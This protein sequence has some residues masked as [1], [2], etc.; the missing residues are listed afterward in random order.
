MLTLDSYMEHPIPVIP[1]IV[2]SLPFVGKFIRNERIG[3]LDFILTKKAIIIH[4]RSW[5]YHE[6]RKFHWNVKKGV[7]LNKSVLMLSWWW[8]K[9]IVI[10]DAKTGEVYIGD[11]ITINQICNRWVTKTTKT[12]TPIYA[13][14]ISLLYRYKGEDLKQAWLKLKRLGRGKTSRDYQR[15]R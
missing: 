2:G 1:P 10:V 14:P 11:P 7:G 5:L 3:G 9:M 4:I 13:C 12:G 6:W 8:K 15:V